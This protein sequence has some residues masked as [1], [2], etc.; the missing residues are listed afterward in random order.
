MYGY[1]ARVDVDNEVTMRIIETLLDNQSS[2][3]YFPIQT[4]K[5]F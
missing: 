2:L 1:D 3:R 5:I 4:R